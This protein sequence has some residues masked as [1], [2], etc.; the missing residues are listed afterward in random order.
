MVSRLKLLLVLAMVR[1][2]VMLDLLYFKI[3]NIYDDHDYHHDNRTL[4]NY[5]FQVIPSLRTTF[6]VV[7][8]SGAR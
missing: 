5:D 3:F 8:M 4:N 1:W 6:P 7:H 2:D